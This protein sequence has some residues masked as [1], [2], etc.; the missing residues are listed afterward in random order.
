MYGN[1]AIVIVAMFW[2]YF[3]LLFFLYGAY[4]NK[5]F[6]PINIVLVYPKKRR[7]RMFADNSEEEKNGKFGE[8]V[9]KPLGH[10]NDEAH[11]QQMQEE[12]DTTQDYL[13]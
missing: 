3:C 5:Y 2:I 9:R 12:I 6:K 11:A 1:F 13:E 4:L 7:D 10:E 8:S